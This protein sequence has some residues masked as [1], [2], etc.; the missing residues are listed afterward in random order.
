MKTK[1]RM[2]TVQKYHA[3]L[4]DLKQ[5]CDEKEE[6]T[7]SSLAGKHRINRYAT[8]VVRN[9][10]WVK[11][12]VDGTY[13]WAVQSPTMVMARNI[14]DKVHDYTNERKSKPVMRNPEMK[15]V[16]VTMNTPIDESK[17][18]TP[19][20]DQ[21]MDYIKKTYYAVAI[22]DKQM[23]RLERHMDEALSRIPETKTYE[24]S[25]RIF[26]IKIYSKTEKK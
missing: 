19:V 10:G 24:K 23:A 26:G 17:S 5:M 13:R 4:T 3:M 7:L 21:Y 12:N 22:M 9:L 20:D 2:K 1:A 6:F 14:A 11:D 25:I 8:S 16:R 18:V 15:P